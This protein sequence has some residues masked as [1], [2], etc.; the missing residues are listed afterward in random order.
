MT[1]KSQVEN[2]VTDLSVRYG[3]IDFDYGLRLA[4]TSEE[5][6]GPVWMVN[7]MRYRDTA[8]YSDGRDSTL[9]GREADDVYAPIESLAAVG[10]EVVFFGDVETQLLGDLPPWDRVAVVKYPTRRSFMDMQ[11]RKEFKDQHHHKDAGMEATIIMGCQPFAHPAAPEDLPEVAQVPHPSTADDPAVMVV[12][13]IAFDRAESDLQQSIEHMTAYQDHAVKIGVANGVQ[14]AGWF[15]VEGT[16]I[17]DGRQWDQ[18]RFNAFPSRAAFMAVVTD[19]ERLAVQ[20]EHRETAMSDTYTMIVRPL[21]N[22][23]G[24][25]YA[26]ALLSDSE[27][28]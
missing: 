11:E 7:L 6:D 24:A 23:I 10:A 2:S 22:N 17:G 28:L 19:P 4:T 20:A 21:I 18:V 25:S 8:Q 9:S 3:Q 16:I 15:N 5:E 14:I 27:D 1:E 26:D 13:V 12:H